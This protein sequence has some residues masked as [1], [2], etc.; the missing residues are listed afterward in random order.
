M[1]Q[2]LPSQP[3]LR[4]R[5]LVTVFETVEGPLRAVDGVGFEIGVAETVALVGESGCGKSVTALSLLGLVDPPGRVAE[6]SI[7]FRGRELRG[8][9]ERELRSVRG[10]E[11]AMVFQEPTTSLNPVMTV[12]RQVVEVFQ[13]HQRLD[14][15]AARRRT[16][17][18]FA[19]VGIPAPE[20][21]LDQYPHQLSGGMRQ[22]VMIAM[23][24]ACQPALLVADEPTTALDVT[25]QAQ[26]LD[27]LEKLRRDLRLSI[28]LITHDL[29]V[30]AETAQRVVVMYAGQVVEQAG[31]RALFAEPL[32]PYTRGLLDSLPRP[33]AG[34]APLQ[35]I[36]G[37][38]PD[39]RR[40]PPGCRFA[41][42]CPRVFDRCREQPVPLLVRPDGR[43]VRCLLYA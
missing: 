34:D 30:V 7:E 39:L 16:A 22:R 17:E 20:E 36:P 15:G 32:H 6:G 26:I 2:P 27:L 25:I 43:S 35:A 24:I 9:S 42:R 8:L 18:L 1:S 5:D 11:I 3:L 40:L 41:E 38:V 29:A 4:V 10:R 12:G 33:G 37:V 28:L 23:A 31:V 13:V 19:L 21:R 14:R